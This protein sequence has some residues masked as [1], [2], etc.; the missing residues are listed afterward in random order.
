VM[1]SRGCPYHC[2]FCATDKISGPYAQRN[3]QAVVSEILDNV[4][5]FDVAD[6]AF[7]DDALLLNKNQRLIPILEALVTQG[8]KLRFHTPNGLH[9]RQID[10]EMAKWFHLS[11]FTTIR[12]SFETAASKR[13]ADMKNKV[14]PADLDQAV[15]NLELAGYPRKHL[16]AYVMMGLPHQT[17]QEI[18]DSLIFVHSLGIKIR[19]AS[20]SP[21]PGTID[22][23]RAV[24]DGLF[25][26]EADPLLTNKTIFPLFRTTVAYK[27]FQHIRQVVRTMNES[28]EQGSS[29]FSAQE[30]KNA[31]HTI[32]GTF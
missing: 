27:Q 10:P 19:L 3:P 6:I 24:K 2:T 20:F 1:T 16:E 11:G 8:V 32:T 29:L 26:A 23:E 25:P 7:Y 14:T 15:R 21:I 22:H 13:L 18:C 31:F 28:V 12:L 4:R 5:R 30:I 9:T 17:F